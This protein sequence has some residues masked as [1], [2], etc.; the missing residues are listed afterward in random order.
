MESI[1]E[2]D[3][4]EKGCK[5]LTSKH[6]LAIAPMSSQLQL[7]GPISIQ[8]WNNLANAIRQEKTHSKATDSRK[9]SLTPT[10]GYGSWFESYP[11]LDLVM[12][13]VYRSD[14]YPVLNCKSHR[15]LD[16]F[17]GSKKLAV[18]P[19]TGQETSVECH[20]WKKPP[21]SRQHHRKFLWGHQKT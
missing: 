2:P 3:D 14:P 20:I 10:P 11:F 5:M 13:P 17:L 18:S 21:A 1:A 16:F 12:A 7:P 8:S 4:G 6:G 9:P 19:T 15:E